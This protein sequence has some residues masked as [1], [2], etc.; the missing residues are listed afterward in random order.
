MPVASPKARTRVVVP[1]SLEDLA[2]SIWRLPRRER[3]TL[4]DL[5]EVRF[6]R[7]VMRRARE[8]PR[9]RKAGKLLTLYDLK[10]EFSR[11]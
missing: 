9:L 10:R 1:I 8:I 7:T 3:E 6:V 2:E 5:L 4:G 11:R